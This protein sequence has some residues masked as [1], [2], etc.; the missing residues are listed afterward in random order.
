MPSAQLAFTAATPTAPVTACGR[1]G[2]GRCYRRNL[3][4]STLSILLPIA[5][6]FAATLTATAFTPTVTLPDIGLTIADR[7][8]IT[9]A[10]ARA[11]VFDAAAMLFRPAN[12]AIGPAIII[13][14]V[15][16]AAAS[17]VAVTVAMMLAIPFV[18]TPGPIAT[19]VVVHVV[20]P[21]A[22][23]KNVE[24][25]ARIPVI[26]IPSATIADIVETAA[27]VAVIIIIERAVRVA[28]IAIVIIAVAIIIIAKADPGIIIAGR[29]PHCR[30]PERCYPRY[31]FCTHSRHKTYPIMYL[32]AL[33]PSWP[34]R[35]HGPS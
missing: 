21:T 29:K 11:P 26:L 13:T 3:L 15:F 25:I 22:P 1:L 4:D 10:F 32:S 12:I 34:I 7:I 24:A 9:I 33:F 6:S 30:D 35:R 27:I 14:P 18:A 8:G 20:A 19:V 23:V 5:T 17:V 31:Q 16:M 2:L 28:A